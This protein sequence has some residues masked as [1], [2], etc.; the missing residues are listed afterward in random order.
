MNKIFKV[1]W[2]K[3][4]QCY[5]V[6]S[7]MAKNTTGKKKIIVGAI[8]AGLATQGCNVMV[9]EA[10][11]P[12]P[13][14]NTWGTTSPGGV[15][16]GPNTSASGATAVDPAT[17]KYRVAPSITIGL[18]SSSAGL[19]TITIGIGAGNSR[20]YGISMGKQTNVTGDYGIAI[21]YQTSVT[22]DHAVA[23]GEQ[24][25]A[26]K[27]GATVMG[28]SARGY[29]Q[30]SV[31]LG[32]Q[33]LAGAD[34]Y[35]S[36]ININS[37]P[38]DDT[39]D[40]SATKNIVDNYQSWG[41]TAIGLRAVA[42]GGNATALGRSAR[43]A[44]EN[45]IAIGGGN[46][47]SFNNNTEKTEATAEKAVA[48]GYN[49]KATA[50]DTLALGTSSKASGS[51]AL[52]IGKNANA[53][54]SDSIAIGQDTLSNN[55]NSVALG[56][57]SKATGASATALGPQAKATGSTAV[58]IGLNSEANQR[59][60]VAVGYNSAASG[61]NAAA[62]GNTAKAVGKNSLALGAN[63]QATVEGG[64]ALGAGSI[65]NTVAGAGYNPN[66][67]R[68][69]TF[70][71]LSGNALTS[72]WAAVSIGDG[73]N[74]RQLTGLAAGTNNTDAV[75]VAQLKSMNLAFAADG[76]T[77]GDVNLT[78]SALNVVGD[79]TYI[80]TKGNNQ[81]LTISGKKQTITV[82][83]GT[84][85]ASAG[86][87]D[88][89][90]V[91]QAI[92]QANAAQ[93]ISYKANGGTAN[94][95]KVSDGLNF[96]NGTTT[97]ATIGA[98]GQVT[99]DLNTTTKQ[100]ITDSS[101]A[102]NRTIA[103]GGSTGSTTAKKLA[104]EDVKFNI[105]GQ[106]GTNALISTSASGDDVTIAPTSKLTDAVTAAENAANKDLSNLSTAGNTKIQNLAKTAA[107][108]NVSTNGSG[109]T[110]VSGGDTVN[111]VNGDNIAVTNTGRTITIGTA[112]NV[113]FDKV[114]V[115]GVVLDKTDGI[116]AGNKEIKGL[117]T[118]T[119][120][121]SAVNKQQMDDA[122]KAASDA[123]AALGKNTIALVG[124][125]GSTTAK[126]LSTS[127]IAFNIKGDTGANALITTTAT[128][129]N[130]S[131]T[132]TAKLTN[133]VAAAENA[134]NKNLSN[135]SS[136]GETVIKNL[137]K[138]AAQDAVKVA[139]TGLATVSDN[140]TGGVKTY[141][142]DVNTG[143]LV[144]TAN[145]QVG[146]AGTTGVSGATGSNG[147]ATTQNVATAINDAVTKAKAST[148][149]ALA[150]AE[151]KF[152]GDTGT[153]SVRKHGEVLSIKGGVTTPADLSTGN[154][155]VVSDGAGTL[156]IRLAKVLSGLTSATFTT[157]SGNT[158]VI[159]GDGVTITPSG[160]GVS[161]ISMTTAGINAGN[162]EIKGVATATSADA[163][164]NKAQMETAIANAQTAATS[165]EK[166]VAKTLSGD[167]NLATVTGQ[168]GTA[169]GETYEVSVSE[170]AVK[171]VAKAAAQDAV[172]VTGT[173]LAT[174]SDNTAA[175]VKTY[176][177]N[178]DEGKLVI[179]DT[180]GKV[181]AAGSTQGTTAGKNG[182][183][184][185]QNVAT[186]I[187][188]AVT[189]ANA[190][191]AQALADAK[192][193]FAGDDATVI[194]RKHGEQLNIKGG[195][196]TTATDL[197]S[198]NIA[199]VGDT[200][201]GTLNIK[202]AKAL[203]G[204]TSATFTDGSGN[205]QTV[206]GGSSTISDAAGN[207]TV[208][209][210]GGVTT[211][212]AAG[213]ITTTAPTGVTVTP[214]GTG[215]TPISVTTSGIS[216]GNKE[217]KNVA[218][219][220]TDDA[221]VNKKQM[222][223]A[224]KA[225]SDA[226]KALG[227]NTVSLG[228]ESGST[229]AKKLSTTGGI[230]FNI[231]GDTGTNALI[232][233]SAT[234]DN[235]TIAPTAKLT[236]A[237]TAAEK[238]ADKDL[239]NL[240]AAGDTYIKN[241][242]KTA[243][244]WNV[245]TN[246]GGT[247]AV[248]GGESVNFINGD[249]IAITNA[250][251]AITI[252]TAKNV[253]FDKVTVGGI[254]LDKTDGI[255]AGGKEVKGIADGTAADSAVSKGQMETA[256][257]NAQTAATSTEKV[258]AKALTGDTNLATVTG[259]TGTAKGE[260]YEVAVSENAVKNVAKAAAQ[261]AVTVTG[262]GLATVSDN[263]AAGVK[264]Y[265]VNVDEGKLVIDDTTG[266]VGAAGSTQGTT[267]GKNGVA[268]T[269]NVATAINDA[270]TKANANNAQAL[271]DAKHNFAGDDAT[272]IS[273]KH[274]E[275]L[276]IKGGASTTATDLTS[277]NIAVVGDTASGTLNIKMAKA[278]TG[279]TSATF[280]DGSGN[281]QTVTGASSTIAD[282]A[283]NTT[284]MTKGGLSTTDGTNTTT[285]AP[286]GVTATDGTNTVKLNGSGIDAGNTQIKN[287]G[288]AT[289][290]DAAVNKKQMDDAVKSATDA[291]T[292]L[293][294]NTIALGS[295]AGSTTVKKLSTNAITF[296]IKGDTGA[297][298][299]IT[300]SATG[301]D[302]TI[303]PTAKLTAAVTAAEKSADKDLS[304]ISSAG[305]TVIKDLAVTS[306]QD[307]VNV[308]GTG[309]ATVSDNT[310]G[311][312]KTYTVNVDEGKLVLD[313]TTGKIG[314]NGSTQGTT[315]G[316]N[317]VATTQNVATAINDAITKS[318]ANTAQA[319][320]D[321]E[322]KFDGDTG[323]TSVRKHG[324]VLSIK[325]GVTTPADLATGNIGV[326]S[327]GAGTL[328][329]R[330]AKVLSGLTSAT[331]KD[332]S[333]NTTMVTG[334]STTIADTAG[335]TQTLA[336]TK[337]E[338]KD[339]NGVS[340]VTTKDGVT[341]KDASGQT[342][343]LTKGGVDATDG[344]G[345]TTS[346][347]NTGVSA[348]DGN[349]HTTGLT[350]GGLST[351]DGTNTTTVVP[352][353]ITA[354]DGTNTVKLNGS[355]IDAGNTQ[356][357]NVG[358]ATTDDAA[359]N[360]KQMDD[361]ITKATADATH[362]FAGD[363][364]NNSVR[365]HGE[366][367]SIKGGVANAADL[368]TGNIGVVSDGAGTLN[369][370]LAKTLTGLTSAT[371]T[372][373]SGNTTMVTGGSTTIADTA[374]NTQTLAPTKSEIKDNN[375][376]ST[377]TT[378]DGVTA[379]DASGQTTS[380][381]KGGVDATD[382]NGHTTGLTNGGLST[383]DGTNTTTVAP[384]GITATDGT[385]TVK[386]EGSGID[387]G[388]TQIKNVGKATTDDAA[389]NKKQMD[390]AITKATADATHEFA[391]DTGNNS[392]RKHG[393][394]L[395]IKG[396]V[397]NAAD[398]TT[399]NIG[400]VSD[401]AGTL[402]IRLAKTLTGL[403]SATFTDA[404]GN[405]TMVTGGSTTIADT[406]G[407][408]QTLAPTK[409]EIKDNNGVSTVTTKDGVTAKDASGQTTSLTKGGINATDGNGNTT[410]LT[411]TGVSATDGHGHTT[412]LTN[413]GLSTTDGTNTTTVAPTGITATDGTNTVKLNGSGIDAGNTQIKNVGKATTDDA[414]VNKKQMDDAI[415]K[416]TADA[417][418]EFAGDTGSNSVRKHG[419]VLSIKGGVTDTN[420]LSDN[421][422]G[423][424]SDGAGT[425]NVKLS[426]DLTG[427]TS[428]TFKDRFGNTQTVTGA[429]STITD[430]TGNTTAMTKGGLSTTDGTNT[431]TIAPTGV[432]ATDGTNIVKLNGSGIDAGNTQ[433]KNVG[434]ATSDDAAVNKKQMDEAV[435]A[436][437]DA[438]KAL[439]NNT[440]TLGDDSGS[441]TTAKALNTT[442][443]IQF[444]I[445]GQ[446][447]TDALITTSA[448]GD[449]VTITPT[450]KLTN[451][452]KAA[453]KSADKDLSNLSAAGNTHIQDLAKS[454]ASWNVQT[455]GNG[456]TAVVGGDT[457][458]FINGDNIAITNTGHAITIGTAKD[459]SFDKVTVGGM[460]L[461]KNGILSG[462]S[463]ITG[464]GTG[465]PTMTFNSQNGNTPAN[466]SIN[467]NLDMGGH[468]ITGV[469]P[470]EKPTDAVN[471][472]QVDQALRGL[473]GLADNA[474]RQYASKAGA[475]AAALAA[476]KPI[477]YDPLEPTQI[478]AGVG[479][480]KSQTAV[481]LG[482]AHYTNENTMFNIGVSL[483]SHD[484][485]VNAGVTHKFGYS[486]EKKAIPDRYK[487]GPI[488]SIY[489]MQDEMQA[490]LAKDQEKDA[491]ISKQASEIDTLR[492]QN[493]DMQRKIDMILAKLQ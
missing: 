488:S 99:Y 476:L 53:S 396:G 380:L 328:N 67:G 345:N 143:N 62:Y 25:R 359:V 198:G 419:E 249:N 71:G 29:G 326:V 85:S 363:T 15:A 310:T 424:I 194:S 136:S 426:K 52:A 387:A 126:K 49:A 454:A 347:T 339:N 94:T 222:D 455:N 289:T 139:G 263:T 284:T 54:N 63:T 24:T 59:A 37:N 124:D 50:G 288:K 261:D 30:G 478:M 410:S 184:T 292:A 423:V 201:S 303:A 44:A 457:V 321:A 390:D 31:S 142:V 480:Y 186:A 111:F 168:T 65:A 104:S 451:A 404:S 235:V 475:N 369:I 105:K 72:T 370:R 356:I 19:D 64:V 119:T 172:T 40:K 42:T 32:W 493:E 439:G 412:G 291:T 218:N 243:A 14:N 317:G 460:T 204:L 490:L 269:Q 109:T 287:V 304:N 209:S 202:M 150:D 178:V 338:I 163:A 18:A 305:K 337:S 175:G 80:T 151:H 357:K 354:T 306:A 251:R 231:K 5:V 223:D 197:T 87:A 160:T 323:T 141:T 280:T 134:A 353:G 114:T 302:V 93:T 6:V 38:Y 416:A 450:D 453:E 418:H 461:D 242:A 76:S 459:V 248:S 428:A 16:L 157:A 444:N 392:V 421:N 123:T 383:T 10:N 13:G 458:N 56:K 422:I 366:V 319:L 120:A 300:T 346:L 83:D 97:V 7:E 100:S 467:S 170:N 108:W 485:M 57:T 491:V 325:G 365:K 489:V 367:L 401:G 361:A 313:D 228:S 388:G 173:G 343:S 75:N 207:S 149:Q 440:I 224:V 148:T 171:N 211:T 154:I 295:D 133:A 371:F 182:V 270:V 239:S 164:V 46:G 252:G 2:S 58:A 364:G 273:R 165:T 9:A 107:A 262:T 233:T 362:E 266:K 115:G 69:N 314:A 466:V 333:G 393:E 374:G 158:T 98:N 103:L 482:M 66:T 117:A 400:V 60:T 385:N 128:G 135:I 22:S 294:N 11:T 349:G 183:A 417:T 322:H 462:I 274:G 329:I 185:T 125:S 61:E 77:K 74:T 203:T 264:T 208:V 8:L 254:V 17:G 309:L 180:T 431:T 220:T 281:T 271:A 78:N 327:D 187:N 342:T 152:A 448:S 315:A 471:K 446:T 479:N 227:D 378:K 344:N 299:L 443:G 21:G 352:T 405:T 129:D 268:T 144:V 192:H 137:A 465:A 389:V 472:Q 456:T 486:P 26:P 376:V 73:T 146:A 312:V 481:A 240:S 70:T 241:L 138:G 348:T 470:A 477:Q 434:K 435:K 101:T 245:E 92:N 156:N 350:N 468:R 140:T 330:L 407:N 463:S 469:G 28:V 255:N 12:A 188:D 253:S 82:T 147:V 411:N 372:D 177:V 259:Q 282:G 277:G 232:T 297:N 341:A 116:N 131:I 191:N 336:P 473:A 487:G 106:T 169:K 384:T 206:T 394:V 181:G 377:V 132:P 272:V 438:T 373:A 122:V 413:G 437:S 238:S 250:G 179:D 43:A 234:G 429:S 452:V 397:A 91:A 445:K 48:V 414:A 391:G 324:E 293:G 161:A 256:I 334:G 225:A 166:V 285:V 408:T 433:I 464:S 27:M 47:N 176:T 425:L 260:T 358:K 4:K 442:G 36:G 39:K 340:T 395:S 279:L 436:A 307:A 484:N 174:V 167:T 244:S 90:N 382:G 79:S 386:V 415:T 375:G 275:Q 301:D 229:T 230:T 212:D 267:A 236:A 427:L 406:A 430:G 1:I 81:T 88:A 335:N 247:T 219:G 409:S 474:A 368:T 110:T 20:S 118:G 320:A 189:K 33:A 51:D 283:G 159:N 278:L 308:T 145:G 286:A 360:K 155:G 246:G 41:D 402:N 113:S 311:G 121:T 296:N 492:Q 95:V 257:A 210:K 96:T 381:T 86:M 316:K 195:A 190:N 216:A 449:D 200:A 130:V 84:A 162:K 45:A 35:G 265:T 441:T 214:A 89:N 199:V 55:I 258:I 331:F 403:T 23:I 351:T 447:G 3:S 298:A 332:A 483:D 68:S 215:T 420:K 217:I 432:T 196:S 318:N 276:N 237:V 221:A 102:V 398:L 153:T 193:N 355:G 379:K 399:G 226:T 112:K 213:N 34:V 127:A 205:T 290:D